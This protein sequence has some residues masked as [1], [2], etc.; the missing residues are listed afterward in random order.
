MDPIIL[1]TIAFNLT[2]VAAATIHHI[3]TFR[4]N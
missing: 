1:Y 3:R 2:I 4:S